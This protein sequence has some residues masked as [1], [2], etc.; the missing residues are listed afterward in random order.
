V[1]PQEPPPADPEPVREPEKPKPPEPKKVSHHGVAFAISQDMVVVSADLVKDGTEIVLQSPS[2]ANDDGTVVRSDPATGL[3]LVK[4]KKLKA[5]SLPLAGSFAGGAVQCVAL[6]TID[7][8][9][10]DAQVIDGTAPA[11][12]EKWTV[13]LSKHP[14]LIGAPLVSGGKVVGVTLGNRDAEAAAIPAVTLEQL[15][16]FIGSDFGTR[17]TPATDPKQAIFQIV[18]TKMETPG[19]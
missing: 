1:R 16:K 9:R 7:L 10:I 5:A 4:L 18:V 2:G 13:A 11:P 17:G 19:K 15:T 14:K 12:G 8:F 6:P 3:A